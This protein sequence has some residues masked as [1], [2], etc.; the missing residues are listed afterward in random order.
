MCVLDGVMLIG[1]LTERVLVLI[2]LLGHVFILLIVFLHAD[3][4]LG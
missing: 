1:Q 4:G 2:F 3:F